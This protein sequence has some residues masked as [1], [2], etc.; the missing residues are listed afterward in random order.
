MNDFIF[1][2]RDGLADVEGV[3]LGPEDAVPCNASIGEDTIT[4]DK[5]IRI[6]PVD[7]CPVGC[8]DTS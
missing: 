7:L 3:H 8:S 1:A 4:I 2:S 5:D 6:G